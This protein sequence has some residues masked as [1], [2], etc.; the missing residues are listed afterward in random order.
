MLSNIST[1]SLCNRS[2]NVQQLFLN[3][4]NNNDNNIKNINKPRIKKT[5][6]LS[7]MEKYINL[8]NKKQS[9]TKDS[10]YNEILSYYKSCNE[11]MYDIIGNRLKKIIDSIAFVDVRVFYKNGVTTIKT[12]HEINYT[13][14]GMIPR[15][16]TPNAPNAP[17]TQ[18][19]SYILINTKEKIMYLKYMK[20]YKRNKKNNLSIYDN[21][22]IY[23]NNDIYIIDSTR[24][25]MYETIT[26]PFN[27]FGLYYAKHLPENDYITFLQSSNWEMLTAFL[28]MSAFKPEEEKFYTN[29][30]GKTYFIKYEHEKICRLNKFILANKI[31]EKINGNNFDCGNKNIIDEIVES[32]IANKIYFI[33]EHKNEE[34][35]YRLSINPFQNIC[36]D[37]KE[38][39]LDY[40]LD[41]DGF[42]NAITKYIQYIKETIWNTL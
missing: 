41:I 24:Y 26:L 16:N 25:L 33:V 27:K 30:Y 29:L 19:T 4:N 31:Y 38:V 17:N 32:I 9:I 14:G 2:E 35:T 39:I 36:I 10:L 15:F 42:E 11:H 28:N 40:P 34:N 20:E 13:I 12:K 37:I 18:T 22:D 8:M 23:N 3:K 21:K 7:T 6:N 1:S 5:T